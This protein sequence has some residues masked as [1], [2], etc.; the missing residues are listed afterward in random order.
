[1]L[2]TPELQEWIR[3]LDGFNVLGSPAILSGLSAQEQQPLWATRV[4]ALR[5]VPP[6]FEAIKVANPGL[7]WDVAMSVRGVLTKPRTARTRL[8]LAPVSRIKNWRPR[9]RCMVSL[10]RFSSKC[11]RN[12]P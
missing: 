7:T 1:M 2:G 11:G 9:P 3:A 5:R 4:E 10:A 8:P 6:L 12:R